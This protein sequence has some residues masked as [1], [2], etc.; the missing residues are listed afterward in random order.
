M[1]SRTHG[2]IATPT[3]LGKEFSVFAFRLGRKKEACK[4][5]PI[6][7]KMNGVLDEEHL[8]GSVGNYNAHYAAYSKPNWRKLS[9]RFLESL[10]LTMNP[11]T[12]QIEVL[13]TS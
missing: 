11:Y 10:E 6:L 2:Q 4:N 13:C 7:A 1:V 9:K 12:T 5:V 3:T 8:L